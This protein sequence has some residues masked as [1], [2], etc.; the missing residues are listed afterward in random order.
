[1]NLVHVIKKDRDSKLADLKKWVSATYQKTG[2]HTYL[3]GDSC[4]IN[5]TTQVP[6][7][8][9]KSLWGKLTVAT[10]KLVIINTRNCISKSF[11]NHFHYQEV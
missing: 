5:Q 8:Y 2:T 10:D 3:F 4:I 7:G 11:S 6:I 9:R 1:M